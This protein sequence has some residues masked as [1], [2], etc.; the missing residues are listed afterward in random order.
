MSDSKSGGPR[1]WMWFVAI[2]AVLVAIFY[3]IDGPDMVQA[4]FERSE[5]QQEEPIAPVEEDPGAEE[6]REEEVVA[7]DEEQAKAEDPPPVRRRRE[8]R[9]PRERSRPTPVEE[10]QR[11][12]ATDGCAFGIELNTARMTPPEDARFKDELGGFILDRVCRPQRLRPAPSYWPADRRPEP[13]GCIPY[14]HSALAENQLCW[15]IV[16][17]R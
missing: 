12:P 10:P 4:A 6:P 3:L 11:E 1:P 16:P 7:V 15:R 17:S 8:P 2:V 9:P 13:T 14:E 5:Q